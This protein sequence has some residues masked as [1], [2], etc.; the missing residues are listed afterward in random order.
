LVLVSAHGAP[1]PNE[2]FDMLDV[3]AV[4]PRYELGFDFL[5][6]RTGYT[7]IP[8]TMYVRAWVFRHASRMKA[9]Q[10]GRLAVV[11]H[12]SAVFGMMRMASAF[13]DGV[14][15]AIGVFRSEADALAWLERDLQPSVGAGG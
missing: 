11:V 7:H 6:D 2:W 9:M 8:D 5:Y 12:E 1:E 4:D 3:V 13:A 10:G 15:T 14:G